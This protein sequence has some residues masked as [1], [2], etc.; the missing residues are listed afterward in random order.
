MSVSGDWEISAVTALAQ[1]AAI[2]VRADVGPANARLALYTTTRPTLITDI[3]ADAA[4]AQIVLAKPCG[5]IVDGALILHVRDLAGALVQFNGQPRWAE[6]IAADGAVLTRCDVSDMDSGGG[7]RIIGGTTPEG[8]TS[9]MLY[10]GGLVQ[11][12]LVALT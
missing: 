11:L 8:Q 2:V 12:G 5:A 6:W 9:P 10:A 1:L 3:H 7:I 4:Q